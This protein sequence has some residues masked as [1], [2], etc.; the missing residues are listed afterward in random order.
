MKRLILIILALISGFHNLSAQTRI[1]TI[2]Q[3]Q[4]T[5]PKIMANQHQSSLMLAVVTKDSVLSSNGFGFANIETKQ[6][7]NSQTLF[8]MASI[9]KTFTALAIVKLARQG[10]LS[11]ND[12]LSK[13]APEIIFTNKWEKTN[14]VKIIHLLEHTSGFDDLRFNTFWNNDLNITE[15]QAIEKCKNSMHCRWR[16]GEREAYCN[17]DYNILGY[18]IE[19]LSGLKYDVFLKNEILLPIGMTNTNFITPTSLNSAYAY[20]YD[21]NGNKFNKLPLLQAYGKGAGAM[22]SCADDMA[23]FVQFMLNNGATDSL[24]SLSKIVEKMEIPESTPAAQ[25]GLKTGYAKGITVDYL[26]YKFPFYLHGGTSIG[27]FSKYAYNRDLKVG[28]IVCG[29]NPN[30]IADILLHFF[31][32]SLPTPQPIPTISVSSEVLK[33]YEGYYQLKSPRFELLDK[34][35]EELLHG[36][37]IELR[38]D[39]LYAYGFKRPDQAILPVTSTIFKKPNETLA[40]F[41]FTTNQEGNKVLYDWGAYY[42]KT[43]YTKILLIRILVLGSLICGV[44]LLLSSIFWLF[45]AIFKKLSWKEYFTRSLSALGVLS[46]IMAFGMLAY[47]GTNVPLMGTVNFFTLTFF[48][49]TILFS[50]LCIAGFIMILKRYRHIT[51][52]WTK[53]YLLVTTTWLLALVF[54]FFHYDWIGLRMWSY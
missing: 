27:F 7:A 15:L 25:L 5:I 52:K 20:P 39:S 54:F 10:K 9:T 32:D 17:V 6:K 40:S 49:G 4:D 37:H 48:I 2:A 30:E 19:K 47:M 36:Y 42:E 35:L 14:P 23:K 33:S 3:L 34:Y 45:K 1:K 43:S 8:P 46:F 50:V 44:L 41:L 21:W 31:T 38:G 22:Y 16:P 26:N 13:I 11:L 29:S 28:F 53:W 18:I 51:N 12:N 24:S